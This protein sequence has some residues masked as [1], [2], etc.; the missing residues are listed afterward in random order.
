MDS[1]KQVENAASEMIR[2]ENVSKSFGGKHALRGVDFR[3]AEGEYVALLGVNGA[4]KTT[5]IKILATLSRPTSGQIA[6]AGDS[7]QERPARVRRLIGVMSHQTFL[8]GD[9]SADENLRFYARMYGVSDADR[10]IDELLHQV[11]LHTRRYDLVRTFSRGMQQRLSLARALL[12]RPKILLLDEPFAGLDIN[13]AA[14]LSELLQKSI[15]EDSTVLITTHDIRF[16]LDRARR[17]LLIKDGRITADEPS[18]SL[19]FQGIAELLKSAE[20]AR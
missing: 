11:N 15:A 7:L 2:V 13:A 14:M 1:R 12:H 9:L 17:I 4:G 19:S 10:R 18:S 20:R 16:A 6:I 5:L 3:I 8:Y